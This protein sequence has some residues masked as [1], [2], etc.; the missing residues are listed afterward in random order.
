MKIFYTPS[1]TSKDAGLRGNFNI[2]IAKIQKSVKMDEA[3]RRFGTAK[4]LRQIMDLS[5]NQF[6]LGIF[7]SFKLL[8]PIKHSLSFGSAKPT[9]M[10]Y[11]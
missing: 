5:D 4:R 11:Q 7:K 10:L 1:Y 3:T 2:I 6:N 9:I 8:Y